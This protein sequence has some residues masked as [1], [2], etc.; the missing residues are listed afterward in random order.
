[1]EIWRCQN[2]LTEGASTD[3]PTV[4]RRP[5]LR[6]TDRHKLTLLPTLRRGLTW[7]CHFGSNTAKSIHFRYYVAVRKWKAHIAGRSSRWGPSLLKVHHHLCGAS[8]SFL[9]RLLQK[10]LRSLLP[11]LPRLFKCTGPHL[12]RDTSEAAPTL[13]RVPTIHRYAEPGHGAQS[14]PSTLRTP[15]G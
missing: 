10:S 1:M 7:Q 13:V 4:V 14:R 5:T 2:N 15:L 8:R 11:E 6:L 9:F 3:L 12:T